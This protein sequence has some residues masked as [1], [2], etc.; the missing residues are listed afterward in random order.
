MKDFTLIDDSLNDISDENLN[1]SLAVFKKAFAL[2]Y[3]EKLENKYYGLIYKNTPKDNNTIDFVIQEV[4]ESKLINRN[5]NSMKFLSFEPK[6]TLIP[7][8]FFDKNSYVNYFKFSF[9]TDEISEDCIKYYHLVAPKTY[10]LY[11]I[12]ETL[13]E[14]IKNK[15]PGAVSVP[16]AATFINANL[17]KNKLFLNDSENYAAMH[18]Y[19]GYIDILILKNNKIAFY[20]TFKFKTGNDLVYYVL[21]VFELLKINREKTELY[22]SGFIEKT[23]IAI[24]NLKKF[25]SIVNFEPINRDFNYYY[26]FQDFSPHYFINFLNINQ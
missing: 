20:N 9:S 16:H 13:N 26:K 4:Y 12:N 14:F 23:D 8:S 24:I 17:K 3:Y 6:T 5:F 15:M 10:V 1:V 18:V 25:I 22:I 7:D 19:D 21:N 2:S 11:E